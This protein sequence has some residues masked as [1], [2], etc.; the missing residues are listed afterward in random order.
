MNKYNYKINQKKG[1][2]PIFFV[3]S[4][5]QDKAFILDTVSFSFLLH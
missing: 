1:F 2:D 4:L 3:A 5:K